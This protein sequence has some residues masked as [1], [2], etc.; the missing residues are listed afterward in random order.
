MDT[1]T[2]GKELPTD[3]DNDDENE[4]DEQGEAGS[5]FIP[6]LLL[7][8]LPQ[9]VSSGPT[10]CQGD[11]ERKSNKGGRPERSSAGN[12]STE[13]VGQWHGTASVLAPPITA[14]TSSFA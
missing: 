14:T 3:E 7:L 10:G 8:L 9:V 2:D 4:E 11:E 13:A 1:S 6:L 5:E 12:V